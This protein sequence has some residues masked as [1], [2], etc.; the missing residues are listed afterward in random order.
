MA[1]FVLAIFS[2][3]ITPS[4]CD[5]T[6]FMP[7]LMAH[8]WAAPIICWSGTLSGVTVWDSMAEWNVWRS[9][10]MVTTSAVPKA[11][12]TCRITLVIDE[13]RLICGSGTAF[14]PAVIDGIITRPMAQPRAASHHRMVVSLVVRSSA[15]ICHVVRASSG[16]PVRMTALAPTL[17]TTRPISGMIT[18]IGST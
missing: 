18:V 15:P 17:S 7:W 13:A 4:A 5:W 14:R 1:W 12:K 8:C 3:I 11:P 2:A 10:R 16:S 6:A 9:W